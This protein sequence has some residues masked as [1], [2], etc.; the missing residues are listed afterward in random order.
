MNNDISKHSNFLNFPTVS[1]SV[2]NLCQLAVKIESIYTNINEVLLS[3][4]SSVDE[5]KMYSMHTP[6]M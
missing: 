2:N 3:G 5:R 1:H 4:Y 6:E